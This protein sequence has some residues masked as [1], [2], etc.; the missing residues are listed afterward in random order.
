MITETR[1]QVA[2]ASPLSNRPSLW[3]LYL[4]WQFRA[5]SR[6]ALRELGP[7]RLA[8]LGLTESGVA[9]EVKKPFWRA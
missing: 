9:S 3:S 7:D 4:T 5:A 1:A 8:D 6:Q 2:P